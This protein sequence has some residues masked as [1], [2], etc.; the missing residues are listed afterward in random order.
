MIELGWA[1]HSPGFQ[2]EGTV[3][4]PDGSIVKGI[5]PRNTWIPVELDG[6]GRFEV[7]LEAASNPILL[8]VV[9]FQATELGDVTTS[10]QQRLYRFGTAAIVRVHTEV[11][12]LVTDIL[13]LDGLARVLNEDSQRRAEIRVALDRAMD[14]VDLDD[15]PR[16]RRRG[17]RTTGRGAGSA[18]RAERA[19]RVRRG[20]RAHR[21]GLVVA[22]AR[23]AS[24]GRPH[25]RERAPARRRRPPRRVRVPCRP[26]LGVAGAGPARAVRA[27][28]GRRRRRRRGAG[29][30]HVGGVRR[31]PARWR[32]DG[33]PAR[34]GRGVLRG[35]LRRTGARRSGCRTPS[36]TRRRCPSSLGW[37][38]LDGSS[39]RR[40]RGTRSTTSRTTPST[41]RASTAPGSS[42]TSRPPTPTTPIC[43]QPSCT[44][45]R[46]TSATRA[47]PARRWCRSGTATAVVDP[48]A[49]CSPRRSA[50]PISRARPGSR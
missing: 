35:G 17:A 10:G 45:R 13:A 23:D 32:G 41:G 47:P 1:D 7:Y 33:P 42:R 6:D 9:P 38:G 5:H 4:R 27:G 40:S 8:D 21:L 29:G 48:R 36:A 44:T 30:R 49:R 26:A 28:A 34:R 22:G 31:E 3:Y 50:P 16:H 12:E 11:R 43:R 18:G 15:I 46:R 2:C 37:P 20:A 19:P 14:A 24:Q 39:R 25:A